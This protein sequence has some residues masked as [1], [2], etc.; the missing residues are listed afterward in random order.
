[1]LPFRK[2]AVHTD[3]PHLLD[4]LFWAVDFCRLLPFLF[5]DLIPQSEQI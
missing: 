1:M 5:T 2:H 3:L 4:K